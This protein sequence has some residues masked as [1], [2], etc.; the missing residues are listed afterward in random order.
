M[1]G[2]LPPGAAT[3]PNAPWNQPEPPQCPDCG[4]FV[5]ERD[6][7]DDGC[8]NPMEPNELARENRRARMRVARD[9]PDPDPD[10]APDGG[11]VN[12]HDGESR[13][14]YFAT[15]AEGHR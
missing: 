11:H 9:D 7:H 6:D 13:D 15:K 4:E 3:D 14:A 2:N 1:T 12:P 5:T 10:V 8:P